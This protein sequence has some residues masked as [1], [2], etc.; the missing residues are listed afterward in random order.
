[1][2]QVGKVLVRPFGK[3]PCAEVVNPGFKGRQVRVE[4]YDDSQGFEMHHGGL[5]VNGAAARGND[6]IFD[7]KSCQYFFFNFPESAVP[8]CI[9]D[10][11]K[12]SVLRRLYQ[13]VGIREAP[14]C[15]FCQYDANGALTR[16]RHAC[17]N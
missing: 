3:S 10:I 1:M 16:A 4:K 7:I 8:V 14:G 9:D 2:V 17:K 13:K 15:H 6:V 12:R 11:L 5:A